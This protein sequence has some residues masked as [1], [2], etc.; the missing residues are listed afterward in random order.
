MSD[1]GVEAR[2]MAAAI[3]TVASDGFD[4]LSID[5]ICERA[6]APR[7]VFGRRWM[8]AAEALLDAFH[9]RLSFPLPDTGA[10]AGDLVAYAQ[11]SLEVFADPEYSA[12]VFNLL[13]Q[14]RL[15]RD[16]ARVVIPGHELRRARDRMLIERAVARG[17]LPLDQDPDALLDAILSLVTA[18]GGTQTRPTGEELAAMVERLIGSAAVH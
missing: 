9:E 17:E 15:D 13:A 2:I 7:A 16:F 11:A 1:R 6:R 4:Q 8:S 12:V 5:T 3:A 18:L 10:L 14:I